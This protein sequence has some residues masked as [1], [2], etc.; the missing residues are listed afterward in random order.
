[1]AQGREGGT[2]PAAGSQSRLSPGGNTPWDCWD[3]SNWGMSPG[4]GDGA[5]GG[6]RCVTVMDVVMSHSVAVVA[7]LYQLL[8]DCPSIALG[9]VLGFTA[10]LSISEQLFPPIC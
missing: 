7:A 3:S 2:E 10:G 9:P 8:W 5:A 1:M 6:V 4:K